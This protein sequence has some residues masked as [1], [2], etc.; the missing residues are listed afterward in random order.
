MRIRSPGF[1]IRVGDAAHLWNTKPQLQALRHLVATL[2]DASAPLVRRE[3]GSTPRT[4]KQL[5]G[6]NVRD[7]VAAYEAGATLRQ[8]ADRFGVTRQTVSNLLK[9][10]GVT[11]RWGRLTSADVDEAERLYAQG[12]SLTRIGERLSVSDDTVR[13]QLKKRGVQMRDPHWRG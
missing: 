4:A 13:Y 8:L 9:R 3:V 11:P 6:Q 10:N 7:L 5:R 1:L 12:L 2:P